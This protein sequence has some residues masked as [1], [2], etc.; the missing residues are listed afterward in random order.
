MTEPRRKEWSFSKEALWDLINI[1]TKYRLNNNVLQEDMDLIANQIHE[2][3]QSEI[4]RNRKDAVK[5][6]A[7]KVRH[8]VVIDQV[9]MNDKCRKCQFEI[10]DEWDKKIDAALKERGIE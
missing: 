5:E 10:W 6:F 3:I 8:G 1:W 2:F 9:R 7:E 4:S